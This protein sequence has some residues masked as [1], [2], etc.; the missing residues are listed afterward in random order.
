MDS[1]SSL[2]LALPVHTEPPKLPV[3]TEPPKPPFAM[4]VSNTLRW[5]TLQLIVTCLVAG[6]MYEH[7]SVVGPYLDKH[8]VAFWVPVFLLFVSLGGMFCAGGTPVRLL[9]F[10]V[11]TLGMSGLVGVS[12]LPYSPEA[13][14][15]AAGTTTLIVG[16]IAIYS[17]GLSARGGNL[18]N[19]GPALGAGL[20]AVL[21]MG[22]ANIFL[23]LPW[24]KIGLAV[25]SVFLFS[26][27]LAYDLTRL[28]NKTDALD[29]TY[30]DGLIPATELYLDVINLFLNLLEVI[31]ACSGD[32]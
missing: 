7:S 29:P 19:L 22:L 32:D 25:V 15:L 5:V 26:G 16:T 17:R 4:F 27:Y 30:N 1:P 31:G 9:W 10:C 28:Y 13:I 11:F 24:L 8:P 20:S 2:H 6:S 21:I 14:L 18:D 12:L 23:H 3:H